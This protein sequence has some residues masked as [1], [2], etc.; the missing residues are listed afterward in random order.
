M[1]RVLS[2]EVRRNITLQGDASINSNDN[3]HNRQGHYRFNTRVNSPTIT[4]NTSITASNRAVIKSPF[5][6]QD[7][8]K[9]RRSKRTIIR[10]VNARVSCFS[11]HN[12]P[13]LIYSKS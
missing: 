7:Q 13:F 12:L 6:D 11:Y 3:G 10:N 2:P 1:P 8:H 9:K 5:S 4:N